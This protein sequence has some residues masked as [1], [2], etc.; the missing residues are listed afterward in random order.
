ML[1]RD[2][3]VG[4]GV[5]WLVDGRSHLSVNTTND[6]LL[7]DSFG[8]ERAPVVSEH[9]ELK[10]VPEELVDNADLEGNCTLTTKSPFRTP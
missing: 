9:F 1:G 7:R 3:I 6:G 8:R 4:K 10:N 5:C 2:N